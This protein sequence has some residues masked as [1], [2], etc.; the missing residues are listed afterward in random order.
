[1]GGWDGIC[2]KYG[3]AARPSADFSTAM[4]LKAD[5]HPAV[6]IEDDGDVIP[7]EQGFVQGILALIHPPLLVGDALATPRVAQPV[8]GRSNGQGINY[9]N[10]RHSAASRP[11]EWG[12]LVTPILQGPAGSVILW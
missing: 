10:I 8:G 1:M 4:A 12:F 9:R 11:V 6:G 3:T 7:V 2:R 5:F